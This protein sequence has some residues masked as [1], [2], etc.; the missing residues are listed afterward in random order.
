M[1]DTKAPSPAD[2]ARHYLGNADFS[3]D[4]LLDLR[5]D[6]RIKIRAI[7]AAYLSE[8]SRRERIEKAMLITRMQLR[9]CIAGK[10][11][12]T[13]QKLLSIVDAA[14]GEP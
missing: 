6:D 2:A 13:A 3:D 14:L 1:T 11:A 7:C 10:D 5:E 12:L 4:Q 9:A 8:L